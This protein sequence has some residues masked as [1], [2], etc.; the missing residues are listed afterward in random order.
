MLG[1]M[2]APLYVYVT[3]TQRT[4]TRT[5]TRTHNTLTTP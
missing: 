2:S 1:Y 4:H 5:Y 3:H